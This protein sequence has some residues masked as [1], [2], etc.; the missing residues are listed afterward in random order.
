M[1]IDLQKFVKERWYFQGINAV[2]A[3]IHAG[4]ISAIQIMKKSLGFNY[5]K[6][7]LIFKDDFCDYIYHRDD[8]HYVA[9]NIIER[10]KK[11][12]DYTKFLLDKSVEE[13]KPFL[14][15]IKSV[16]P[17]IK[18]MNDE[19]L[20]KRYKKFSEIFYSV[21]GASHCIEGFSLTSDILI[22]DLLLK[23]LQKKGVDGKFTYYFNLLMQP[24]RSSFNLESNNLMNEIT[25]SYKKDKN[26]E[27]LFELIDNYIEKFYWIKYSWIGGKELTKEDVL[28]EIKEHI[29][30]N[31]EIKHIDDKE[32]QKNTE[33]KKK[34]CE[35]LEL[36]DELR[37]YLDLTEF[38]TYWQDDRKIN[39][40]MGVFVMEKY[41]DEL[42]KRSG[43]G[44]KNLKYVLPDEIESFEDFNEKELKL[45]R[46]GSA[47]LYVDDN[48]EILV[49]KEF[50]D[51]EK[52]LKEQEKSDDLKEIGGMCASVG[53]CI[54]RV[55]VCLTMDDLKKLEEGDVLVTS[56]TRPEFFQAMKTAAAFVTDEGG[57]TCHAAIVAREFNK[58]CIIAT[59]KATKLLKDGDLVEVNADHGVVKVIKNEEGD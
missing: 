6:F 18:E 48:R 59:K 43:I 32:L 30:K 40:L 17:K 19:E 12:K 11:D 28:E 46:K 49:G 3:F 35:E 7:I 41:V 31:D 47:F 24:T 10:Y 42:A 53:K 51:F 26:G 44:S 39:I 2:P 21:F 50:E 14:E 4:P 29:E 56:M 38:M 9:N 25:R 33:I 34:L 52:M 15:H 16:V 23:A 54:G 27:K 45:R 57:I 58:P 36:D 13:S 22:K 1:V 20:L 37:M 5:S 55:K 8:L